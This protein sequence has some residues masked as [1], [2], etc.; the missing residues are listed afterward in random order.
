MNNQDILDYDTFSTNGCKLLSPKKDV[1]KQIHA[2]KSGVVKFEKDGI[3]KYL[4]YK[5]I[6]VFNWEL[7]VIVDE[8][9]AFASALTLKK[10]YMLMVICEVVILLLY[11]GFYIAKVR[12]IS[13]K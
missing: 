12:R 1:I 10:N 7:I 2:L 8:D 5:P 6:E 3:K 4:C 9:V 11:C 13:N